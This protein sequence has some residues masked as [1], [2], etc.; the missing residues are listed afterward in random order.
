M[1]F[2][3]IWPWLGLSTA[4]Y[5]CLRYYQKRW[6]WLEDANKCI[7]IGDSE[8]GLFLA[9]QAIV[10]NPRDWQAHFVAAICLQELH[11]P[12]RALE[13]HNRAKE[14]NPH[15]DYQIMILAYQAYCNAMLCDSECSISDATC[16]LA[17][18]RVAKGPQSLHRTYIILGIRAAVYAL[19]YK[20]EE[21]IAD[22]TE[23]INLAPDRH[24][25][26]IFRSTAYAQMNDHDAARIDLENATM[27]MTAATSND[28]AD[29][30]MAQA[31][32][33]SH[34]GDFAAALEDISNAIE[35]DSKNPNLY[36]NRGY[37]FA[38]LEQFDRA[39]EELD[40]AEELA[41]YPRLRSYITS[42]RARIALVRND[43]VS[44]LTLSEQALSQSTTP[45]ALCTRA[46]ALLR[47]NEVDRAED[48]LREAEE[49]HPNSA[50][51]LWLK[52]AV[53]HARGALEEA[54][55]LK[56]KALQLGYV[57]GRLV[58]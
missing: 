5:L 7:G 35:I 50:E 37:Y 34:R 40:K 27:L 36:L 41:R 42:N 58:Q 23:A 51:L 54:E 56:Q 46:V 32:L 12:I 6:Q 48:D 52:G 3:S 31:T 8:R 25:A 10:R 16:A 33:S 28:T 44:G 11:D 53:C 14:S 18:Q 49:K 43:L 21:A 22:L 55:S 19:N 1:V 4:I 2:D 30:L 26:Y 47:S 13:M 29:L 17:E 38:M 9:E 15:K 57:S 20:F 45:A 24:S 39:T